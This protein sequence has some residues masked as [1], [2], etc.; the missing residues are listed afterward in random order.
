MLIQNAV[1]AIVDAVV[2]EM[3]AGPSLKRLRRRVADAV[4]SSVAK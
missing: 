1:R 3:M 2:S 4:I